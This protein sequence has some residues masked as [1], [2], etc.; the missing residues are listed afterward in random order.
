[1]SRRHTEL[2]CWDGKL[3]LAGIKDLHDQSIVGWS[4][5]GRQTTDLV[6]S[7]LVMALARRHVGCRVV[8]GDEYD[9]VMARRSEASP[10]TGTM[11]RLDR[12]WADHTAKRREPKYC[13]NPLGKRDTPPE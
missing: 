10:A 3:F 6:V 5:G 12:H 4:M 1:M 13:A 8:H 7:A 11:R 2:K 9:L